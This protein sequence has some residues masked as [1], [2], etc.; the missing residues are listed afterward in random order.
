[1]T[2][3]SAL[4]PPTGLKRREGNT[5]V[6]IADEHPEF[7]DALTA[8]LRIDPTIDVVGYAQNPADL[9]EQ[10]ARLRLDVIIVESDGAVMRGAALL[11][12]LRAAAAGAAIILTATDYLSDEASRA[13]RAGALGYIDK[14]AAADALFD[15]IWSLR[16]RDLSAWLHDATLPP[17]ARGE[18]NA[19]PNEQPQLGRFETATLRLLSQGMQ[20][21]EIAA[22]LGLP[23][24]SVETCLRRAMV[25]LGL[26]NLP[27][28]Y[29]CAAGQEAGERGSEGA[30]EN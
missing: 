19:L 12:E 2:H 14:A 17:V 10:V 11:D 1:M 25:K 15:L 24:A 30:G 26:H 22:T 3:D 29:D 9:L 28:L 16:S 7:V 18:A 27:A 20:P 4:N 8:F 13:Q 6:L 23:E 5:R 21:E